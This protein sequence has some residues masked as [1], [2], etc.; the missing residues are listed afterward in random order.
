MR[1]DIYFYRIS[2]VFFLIF[3]YTFVL[4]RE[5]RTRQEKKIMRTRQST[6]SRTIYYFQTTQSIFKSP[7]HALVPKKKLIN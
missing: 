6:T 5:T 7:S 3:I 1:L 2:F 4:Q